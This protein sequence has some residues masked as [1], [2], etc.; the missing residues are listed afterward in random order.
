MLSRLLRC[1][2]SAEAAENFRHRRIQSGD[3][4]SPEASANS[5]RCRAAVRLQRPHSS[6]KAGAPCRGALGGSIF[7]FVRSAQLAVLWVAGIAAG[8]V[9]G[10]WM[11]SVTYSCGLC[12]FAPPRFA[13]WE[14]CLVGCGVSAVLF[15]AIIALDREFVP[16]TVR[17]G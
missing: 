6:S 9:A 2:T 11:A 8:V 4:R 16:R 5:V 17:G 12:M 13:A 10:L 3:P 7:H 15:G 1:L 14:S